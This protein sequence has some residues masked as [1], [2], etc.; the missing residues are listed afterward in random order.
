MYTESCKMVKEKLEIPLSSCY[1]SSPV[2]SNSLALQ[3]YLL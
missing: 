2:V 3:E 1:V